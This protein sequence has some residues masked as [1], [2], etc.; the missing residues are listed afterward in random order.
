MKSDSPHFSA[1]LTDEII[2]S[3]QAV[4]VLSVDKEVL[5]LDEEVG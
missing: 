4:A 2:D 1:S 3:F 5:I